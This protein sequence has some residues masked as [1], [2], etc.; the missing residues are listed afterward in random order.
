MQNNQWT[1]Y[2]RALVIIIFAFIIFQFAAYK[3]QNRW[4]GLKTEVFSLTKMP[5]QEKEENQRK[6]YY[7]SGRLQ[8]Q[9]SYKNGVAEG[10][11][12]TYYENGALFSIENFVDGKQDGEA[13]YYYETGELLYTK[14]YRKGRVIRLKEFDKKG[15][16]IY[17]SRE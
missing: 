1:F 10:I 4:E 5:S 2:I 11:T 9:I 12:K 3:L 14:I 13:R 8:A 7:P 17:E 16:L 6:V 15:N